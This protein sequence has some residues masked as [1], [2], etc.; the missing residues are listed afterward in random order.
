MT[1]SE[2]VKQFTRNRKQ[3]LAKVLGGK[4]LLCGF[5]AF[6]EGLDFHHVDP[7]TKEFTLST[8]VMKSLDK[9]LNE[10]RKCVLLCANCHRGVHAGY[11]EIPSSWKDSFNEE[12]ANDLL[13][14]NEKM[15]HGQTY[16]CPICGAI[17]TEK[18]NKCQKCARESQR[19]VSRPSREELKSLIRTIP[20]TQI[21]K[22]Y[23]VSDN[24]IRKWCSYE[25]LPTK[26]TEINKISDKDWEQI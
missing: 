19:I 9:Q 21:A 13:D 17:V 6:Q 22:Q 11:Y 10:A 2:T 14:L 26:K 12:L 24:A 25:H 23:G 18:G 8:N 20:F 15:R 16:Y 5:N 3:N 4:C 7:G 1:N